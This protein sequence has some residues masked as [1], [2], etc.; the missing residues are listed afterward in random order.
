MHRLRLALLGLALLMAAALVVR[1]WLVAPRPPAP[2][3]VIAPIERPAAPVAPEAPAI[4]QARDALTLA[5]DK[6]PAYRRFFERLREA[7]PADHARAA[8]VAAAAQDFNIDAAVSDSVRALRQ[9]RGVLAARATAEPLSR[10]FDLQLAAL[11]ALEG[12][13]ARACVDFLYGGAS[14]GLMTFSAANR[15]VVADLALA[16]LEAIVDGGNAKIDRSPPGEEDFAALEK[17]LAA[18]GL[19]KT[20]IEALLDGRTP[21][22]PLDDARMCKSGQ[23]YLETLR[24]LPEE[25]RLRIYALAV[26]LMARS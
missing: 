10:V 22:P 5:L 12:R 14:E 9:A 16:G 11:K 17:A 4:R 20:E 6:A 25:I 19:E 18:K 3:A 7:F 13:D 2:Q 1:P 15:G 21:E 8:Q 26:E 24:E 23:I